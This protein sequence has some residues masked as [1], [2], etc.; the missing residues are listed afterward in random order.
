MRKGPH[1]DSAGVMGDAARTSDWA[2]ELAGEEKARHLLDAC[3]WL[4]PT[5]P[6]E[7]E[8]RVQ[9]SSASQEKPGCSGSEP[10]VCLVKNGCCRPMQPMCPREQRPPLAAGKETRRKTETHVIEK[11]RKRSIAGGQAHREFLPPCAALGFCY[12]PAA[13]SNARHALN[14]RSIYGCPL[15]G[16]HSGHCSFGV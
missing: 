15:A 2:P 1:C 8:T 13:H 14:Q 3:K 9:G 12:N 16:W 7:T 6:M 4:S 5:G 10:P 11:R